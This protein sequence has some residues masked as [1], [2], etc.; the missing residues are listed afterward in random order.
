MECPFCA[1]FGHYKVEWKDLTTQ[2]PT[3]G[4]LSLHFRH[5]ALALAQKEVMAEVKESCEY[6]EGQKC[7]VR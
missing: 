7:A 3:L 2:T 6:R 1:T 4:I 5:L